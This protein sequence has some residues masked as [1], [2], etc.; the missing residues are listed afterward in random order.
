MTCDSLQDQSTCYEAPCGY[1]NLLNETAKQY[2]LSLFDDLYNDSFNAFP[3]AMI[4]IG[5][6]EVSEKCFGNQ[7][8]A[9]YDEWMRNRISYLLDH[10]KT[11]VM[12]ASLQSL[13][14]D[15]GQNERDIVMYAWKCGSGECQRD[16]YNALK[17]GYKVVDAD[18]NFYYLDCGFAK[19]QAP[20]SINWCRPYRTWA[21]IYSHS[22]YDEIPDN[23]TELHSNL[24]GMFMYIVIG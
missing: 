24:L 9:L 16:K 15:Y 18:S 23:E 3:D 14:A 17:R 7:T 8:D 21:V 11:P 10:N 13:N 1:L 12:W 19:W 6:D 20:M 22:L 2:V 4:H 5:G